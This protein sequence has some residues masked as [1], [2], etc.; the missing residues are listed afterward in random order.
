MARQLTPDRRKKR[1]NKGASV[2]APQRTMEDAELLRVAAFKLQ[3][4]ANRMKTLAN[5]ARSAKLRTRLQSLSRELE[6]Y[7]SQ[8]HELIEASVGDR[9]VHRPTSI[10][11]FRDR[12]KKLLQ[13]RR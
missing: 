9:R 13:F 11:G 5:E 12:T 6:S 10:L 8:L 3:E 1:T 2:T 7:E 4:S